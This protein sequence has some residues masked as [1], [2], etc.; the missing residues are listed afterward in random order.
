MLSGVTLISARPILTEG[1]HVMRSVRAGGTA[2]IL[3]ITGVVASG[4][5]GMFDDAQRSP[6]DTLSPEADVHLAAAAEDSGDYQSAVRLLQRAVQARPK[7][8]GLRVAQAQA[9]IAAGAPNDAETVLDQ[10]I[11]LDPKRVDAHFLLGHL[12]LNEHNPDKALGEFQVVLAVDPQQVRALDARG[13]ACDM[14]GRA[15]DAQASYRAA[16]AISPDDQSTRNN[17]GLSLALSG[18]Y[19]QAIA[20]LRKLTLEPGATPRMRENLSLALGLKGQKDD[21]ARVSH[22]DLDQASIDANQ[23]YFDAVRALMNEPAPAAGKTAPGKS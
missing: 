2:A 5:A 21:A 4:C 23:Q 11:A 1:E 19:D 8:V 9:L 20:I 13:V 12:D 22:G 14:L 18:D 3:V 16:L 15:A 6:V 7:D 17:L 10:A